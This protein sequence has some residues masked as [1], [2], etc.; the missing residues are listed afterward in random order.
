MQSSLTPDLMPSMSLASSRSSKSLPLFPDAGHDHLMSF[1][2]GQSQDSSSSSQENKGSNHKR[3]VVSAPNIR[4][5]SSISSS[6][7]HHSYDPNILQERQ[8]HRNT[9]SRNNLKHEEDCDPQKVIDSLKIPSSFS[10][11]AKHHCYES[12][13]QGACSNRNTRNGYGS[14]GAAN[15]GMPGIPKTGYSSFQGTN[16]Q[17]TNMRH[18][19][20]QT[21][22]FRDISLVSS[23]ETFDSTLTTAIQMMDEN[24]SDTPPRV[25]EKYADRENF[26]S[27]MHQCDRKREDSR[28]PDNITI[29]DELLQRRSSSTNNQVN[30]QYP[31][32]YSSTPATPHEMDT[33]YSCT[34]QHREGSSSAEVPYYPS[35]SEIYSMNTPSF[36]TR[37]TVPCSEMT[38]SSSANR[39]SLGRTMREFPTDSKANYFRPST[40]TRQPCDHIQMNHT[41]QQERPLS[42]PYQRTTTQS[43]A[44][45]LSSRSSSERMQPPD[46]IHMYHAQ[47]QDHPSSNHDQRTT[48]SQAPTLSTVVAGNPSVYDE[49]EIRKKKRLAVI[50][51]IREVMDRRRNAKLVQDDDEVRL[52]TRHLDLLNEELDSMSLGLATQTSKKVEDQSNKEVGSTDLPK[53]TGFGTEKMLDLDEKFA[54]SERVQ[55]RAPTR[56]EVYPNH[57]MEKNDT[58]KIRA[59]SDMKTG[60]EF[61]VTVQG[62]F[63]KAVV[64]SAPCSWWQIISL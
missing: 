33:S 45:M 61:T 12:K 26:R 35:G 57:T 13:N 59:P 38:F 3:S 25:D 58:I 14:Y 44:P 49:F 43:Q 7:H 40:E 41:Q 64:V 34:D 51:E 5:V 8:Q 36:Q 55:T 27:N 4:N 6:V 11:S 15:E 52:M 50:Q 37:A 19:A 31:S 20:D 60:Y 24:R 30:L 2:N 17:R 53:E 48:L 23:T 29:A 16:K 54:K 46:H 62:K 32:S 22:K 18:H 56:N 10:S 39:E 9:W 28:P 42:N 63:V 1:L 21:P 47:K